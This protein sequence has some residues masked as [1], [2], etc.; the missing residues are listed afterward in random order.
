MDANLAAIY[1]SIKL[2]NPE[3]LSPQSN[4]IN[5]QN[6]FGSLL[7]QIDMMSVEE[8][9]TNLY[10]IYPNISITDNNPMNHILYALA[11][12]EKIGPYQVLRNCLRK[13]LTL[14]KMSGGENTY[15]AIGGYST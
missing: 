6:P 7:A 13:V 14:F 4:N 2:Y 10:D 5:L 15:A 8:V 3:L 1:V 9:K 11:I 12:S